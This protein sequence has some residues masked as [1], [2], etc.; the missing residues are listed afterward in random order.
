MTG[1][2]VYFVADT[3][4]SGLKASTLYYI[5]QDTTDPEKTFTLYNTMKGAVEA[6]ASELVNPTTAGTNV[7]IIK[8]NVV[9][10]GGTADYTIDD[11]SAVMEMCYQ[12]GGNP[13]LAIMSPAKKRRFSSLVTAMTTINRDMKRARQLDL[14]ADVVETDYGVITA[15]SHRMYPD[16]RVDLMDMNYWDLKWFVRTH[17]VPGIAKTGS[18]D[19]FFI[20]SWLGLQGTQPKASGAVLGIKR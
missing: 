13:T 18:Y 11:L 17:E 2:F 8:N 19:Q 7:K 15:K 16:N 9:D 6:V 4:P 14:V 5:R 1:D 20:E 3:L 10:L 12:R